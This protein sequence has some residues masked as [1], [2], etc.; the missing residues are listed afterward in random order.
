VTLI[1][2]V[3]DRRPESETHLATD[4]GLEHAGAQFAT[5]VDTVWVPTRELADKPAGDVLAGADGLLVAPGSPYES[6]LGALKAI[7]WAR[8]NDV[9]LLG[10]CGGFQHM[11]IE[12][13]RNVAGVTDAAHAEYDPYASNLIVTPLACSVA[14]KR[15]EVDLL[16]ASLAANS[17]GATRAR[18]RYY[19]NFG[20][21]PD[22]LAELSCA[23]LVVSGADQDGEPR[24]IELPAVRFFIGTLFVPQATSTP[25]RPHPLLLA[26]VKGAAQR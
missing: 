11:I 17:Y 5:P 12:F 10:T 20:L 9:P 8:V 25:G 18:E 1:A 13:A 26:L 6:M 2:V 7:R 16:P 4:A 24:V 3:G 23:G 22:R 14:G 19:C 21:N 15:M